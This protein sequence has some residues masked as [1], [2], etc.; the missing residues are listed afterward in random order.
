MLNCWVNSEAMILFLTP[1]PCAC[2][3]DLFEHMWMVDTIQRLGIEHYFHE[4][5]SDVL[6]YVYRF[7]HYVL[8]NWWN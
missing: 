3:I 1:A 2:P 7:G 8:F 6:D 4:E 5:I